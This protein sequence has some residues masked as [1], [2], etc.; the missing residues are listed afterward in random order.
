MSESKTDSKSVRLPNALADRVNA[1]KPMSC[2]VTWVEQAFRVVPVP[3]EGEPSVPVARDGVARPESLV[4]APVAGVETKMRVALP[5]PP[6]ERVAGLP[7]TG[8]AVPSKKV[9]WLARSGCCEDATWEGKVVHLP[10]D[11]DWFFQLDDQ[12]REDVLRRALMAFRYKASV[13]N[14][15]R[16]VL[17][18]KLIAP[19]PRP[20]GLGLSWEWV[21]L[22]L[23][24]LTS[25][26]SLSKLDEALTKLGLVRGEP[27]PE[28]E[29]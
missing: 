28:V 8:S 22:W 20:E 1:I 23:P 10:P 19:P 9:T 26:A 5:E 16:Q 7:A 11:H 2:R 13:E 18:G 4:E 17:T 14:F 6:A 24:P 15:Q 3:N 21:P 27:P 29:P 25:E 12:G